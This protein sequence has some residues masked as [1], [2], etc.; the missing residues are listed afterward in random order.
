MPD[1]VT[2]GPFTLYESEAYKAKKQAEALKTQMELEKSML[3]LEKLK[4]ENPDNQIAEAGS[5]A[6][7]AA[8]IENTL[9]SYDT[10]T[11]INKQQL[12]NIVSASTP[13]DASIS[14][15]VM[16]TDAAISAS[17]PIEQR[18]EENNRNQVALRA[19][20][21]AITKR[22]GELQGTVNLG[23][24]FGAA[25]AGDSSSVLARRT[26]EAA[27]MMQAA[28]NFIRTAQT[29][30]E[31]EARTQAVQ[32]F[33]PF[34][35][36][37]TR[38]RQK[39]S[40]EIAGLQGQALDDD[41]AKKAREKTTDFVGSIK[42]LDML[43]QIKP[44]LNPL[45]R[46]GQR[47]KSDTLRA[48]LVGNLRIALAGP[49][50]LSEY[51]RKIIES[52]IANPATYDPIASSYAIGNL[53]QLKSILA[54][55]YTS[56]MSTYGYRVGKLQDVI[57]AGGN[58]PDIDTFGYNQLAQSQANTQ[59]QSQQPQSQQAPVG[60]FDPQTGKIIRF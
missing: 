46:E 58:P 42:A 29:P 33:K 60:R 52:A 48:A 22:R 20:L 30:E 10:N 28:N 23:E 43:M 2:Y 31:A 19:Q 24:N 50:Q 35:D 15:P 9:K 55:K 37:E 14:G 32:M 6:Q 21:E 44:S 45:E 17:Q 7:R 54:A 51:E 5:L 16:P 59:T 41:A 49:G 26:Q 57:D 1:R 36:A 11:A 13:L 38:R 34:F 8:G 12:S 40:L 39:A 53:K 3:E 27:G 47:R 4:R 18:I 25:P 56:D